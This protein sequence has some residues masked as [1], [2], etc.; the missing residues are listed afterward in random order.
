MRSR[1]TAT[2]G[3]P[4][5]RPKPS[6]ASCNPS[7]QCEKWSNVRIASSAYVPGGGPV[8]HV[9][10]LVA[11]RAG[12]GHVVVPEVSLA[13]R[14]VPLATDLLLGKLWRKKDM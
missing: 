14:V 4:T 10:R 1:C 7:V 11:G 13:D 8:R 9:R 6:T 5:R 2:A 3:T 12:V